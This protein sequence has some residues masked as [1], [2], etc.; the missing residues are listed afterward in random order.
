M[1]E[2]EEREWGSGQKEEAKG[3]TVGWS[4]DKMLTTT[5]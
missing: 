3:V 1:E 4:L 5:L 2:R